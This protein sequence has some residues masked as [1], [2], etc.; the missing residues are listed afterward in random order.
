MLSDEERQERLDGLTELIELI[1]PAVQQDGG[2]LTLINA[3]VETGVVDVQ[4]QGSCSSCAI[5]TTTLQAGIS[6][7][8]QDRLPWVTEVLGDVDDD[9]DFETSSAMGRGAY[10]PK[11]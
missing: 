2:D 6:R 10:V 8:L 7:I 11:F 1:R 4:L 3:D 9:I 5:S